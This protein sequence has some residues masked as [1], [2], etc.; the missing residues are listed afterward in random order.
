MRSG[1]V[2]PSYS[3]GNFRDAGSGGLWWSS[4]GADNVWG[5]AGLGGYYLIF[6]ATSVNSSN[7][8]NS[9]YYAFSLR[10]LS[11]VLGMWG[12]VGN[13]RFCLLILLILC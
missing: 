3:A 13:K 8:P 6:N 11:T 2:G 9:R 10:C 4:R 1:H 12:D 5:S 7:G